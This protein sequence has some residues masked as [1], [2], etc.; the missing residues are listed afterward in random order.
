MVTSMPDLNLLAMMPCPLKVPL[1]QEIWMKIKQM[2]DLYDNHVLRY[3]IVSNA[4]KQEDVFLDV[5]EAKEIGD[6]PDIMIAPGFSRFFYPDFVEKFRNKGY[7]QSAMNGRYSDVYRELGIPDPEG[8]YDI[9]AFNPLVFLVDKTSHPGLP[10]PHCWEDLL[11]PAYDKLVAYRGHN[12]Q[13]FCEGVL[14]TIFKKSGYD[15]IRKLA[16]TVK[17]SM[18]PAEMVQYAGTG[19]DDAPAVSVLP[20]SFAHMVRQSDK[21]KLVWPDDGAIVNPLVMLV[22]KDV[23]EQVRKLGEYLAGEEL[24]KTIHKAGFYSIHAQEETPDYLSGGY[25]WLGWDFLT[26]NNLS[27]LMTELNKM[28]CRIIAGEE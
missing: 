17:A 2:E 13:S 9:I 18:H 1:E 7:F 23:P 11:S 28:M 3:Q 26:Q 10:T 6:L 21:V 14:L 27:A 12:K 16:K 19:K 22:K 24:G 5:A 20:A 25:N 8:W 4:V 15:G